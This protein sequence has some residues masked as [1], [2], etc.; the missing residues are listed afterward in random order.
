VYVVKELQLLTLG[1]S[2]NWSKRKINC[3]FNQ[4]PFSKEEELSTAQTVI[5]ISSS[6]ITLIKKLAKCKISGFHHSVQ[7]VFTV[8]SCMLVVVHPVFWDSLSVPFSRLKYSFV[9]CLTLC[10]HDRWCCLEMSVNSYHHTLQNLPAE[11]RPR[12][13]QLVG[14]QLILVWTVIL[15]ANNVSVK[16]EL[17]RSMMHHHWHV[18][19]TS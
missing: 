19:V 9:D 10:R 6:Y 7:E 13:T 16:Q 2:K 8:L 12:G 18:W 1:M 14:W 17:P 4:S 3:S 15:A 5:E 11:H